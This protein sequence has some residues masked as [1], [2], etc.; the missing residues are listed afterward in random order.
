MPTIAQRIFV[1]DSDGEQLKIDTVSEELNL[2]IFIDDT[3]ATNI[4]VIEGDVSVCED[5]VVVKNFPLRGVSG[6]AHIDIS[7]YSREF[8][9][10]IMVFT[11]TSGV[12]GTNKV[13]FSLGGE[14]VLWPTDLS[15]MSVDDIQSISMNVVPPSSGTDL[16]FT[17]P[18]GVWSVDVVMIR[19]KVI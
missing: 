17:L 13:G 2:R 4:Y 11:L 15:F 6:T 18:S 7:V 8:Y 3:D 1:E 12:A 10:A 19:R 16:Y 5:M 14:D 9:I